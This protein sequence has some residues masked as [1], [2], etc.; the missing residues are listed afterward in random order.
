VLLS[1]AVLFAGVPRHGTAGF[2]RRSIS[3]ATT[4]ITRRAPN[5]YMR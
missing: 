4:V 5:I 3:R 2:H 1:S